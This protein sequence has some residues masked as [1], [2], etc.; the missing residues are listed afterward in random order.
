MSEPRQSLHQRPQYAGQA[1]LCLNGNED[2]ASDESL[3]VRRR[4]QQLTSSFCRTGG[5]CQKGSETVIPKVAYEL[6]K[7]LATA[8]YSAERDVFDGS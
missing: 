3:G 5:S 4:Q 2:K 6:G 8:A 1:S 7:P